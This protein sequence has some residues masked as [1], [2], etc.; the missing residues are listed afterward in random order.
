M[1][2]NQD[3]TCDPLTIE[4]LIENFLQTPLLRLVEIVVEC[5]GF[6]NGVSVTSVTLRRTLHCCLHLQD[7]SRQIDIC[8]TDISEVVFDNLQ[9]EDII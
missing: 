6:H 2:S 4:L 1:L 8:L 7:S 9:V 3:L 5:F